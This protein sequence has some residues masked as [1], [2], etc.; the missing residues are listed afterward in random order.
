MK[1][2]DIAYANTNDLLGVLSLQ[3]LHDLL[4]GLSSTYL[5]ILFG[6]SANL[7]R[8][9]YLSFSLNIFWWK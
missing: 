7:N 1:L 9:D 4:S 6:L 2:Y 8:S 5:F 3:H